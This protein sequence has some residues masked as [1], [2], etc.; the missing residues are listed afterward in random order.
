VGLREAPFLGESVGGALGFG[1]KL[2]E[3]V[4]EPGVGELVADARFH[5]AIVIL[6]HDDAATSCGRLSAIEAGQSVACW[7]RPMLKITHR[8]RAKRRTLVGSLRPMTS[9][10]VAECPQQITETLILCTCLP[11]RVAG[12]QA[13]EMLACG[14]NLYDTFAN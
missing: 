11:A 4:A 8:S 1:G 12:L 9:G 14:G 7:A 10:H 5:V 13:L 2:I 6:A 3:S